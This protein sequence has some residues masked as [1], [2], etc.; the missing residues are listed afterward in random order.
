VKVD[1]EKYPEL[2]REWDQGLKLELPAGWDAELP[3]FA[4]GEKEATRTAGG[5]AMNAIAEKVPWLVGGDA[6]L[7]VSTNTT[8]KKFPSFEAATGAGRNLHF[9]VREHAMTGIAN[10]ICYHGGLRPFVATFFTFSDYERP[11]VRLAALNALP[12][13]FVWTHDSIGLGEDGPTHQPV[14]Q[15]MSLRAMP[16]LTIIRPADA[17]E[18]VEAWRAAMRD[19]EGPV[20][21]VLSRQKLPVLDR[22]RFAAERGLARGAYVLAEAEGGPPRLVLIAS[23][24]EVSLAVQARER[25]QAEGTATRVVSMPSWELFARQTQDYRDS[26]LPPAVPA[27]LAIEA[28]SSLG[29]KR[30]VGDRGDSVSVDRFG[31]SAPGE[32]VLQ[33]L[34]FSVDHI[35]RRARALLS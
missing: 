18:T 32:T 4:A 35:V 25:L 8:L 9:G 12:V 17:N 6:D 10:G 1:T 34:G 31:A 7:G 21:L 20:G 19:T 22:T 29:W 28:G 26:V 11:A 2:A 23:G 30:W 15:L 13:L 3:K 24:S 27:R 14:E 16:G 33:Q 5:K